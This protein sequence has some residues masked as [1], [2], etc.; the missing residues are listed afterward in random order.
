MSVIHE[1]KSLEKSKWNADE[2]G[3]IHGVVEIDT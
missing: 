3:R 2:I 1:M